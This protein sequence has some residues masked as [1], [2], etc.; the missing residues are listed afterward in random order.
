MIKL[1]PVSYTMPWSFLFS[2][3]CGISFAVFR[4][5]V[6][7]TVYSSGCKLKLKTNLYSTI[8]SED[9]EALVLYYLTYLSHSK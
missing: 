8:K 5:L 7:Y 6:L 1:I 3:T 9:S 2:V 4:F